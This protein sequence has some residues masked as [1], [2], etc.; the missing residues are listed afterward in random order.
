MIAYDEPTFFK[1]F[2]DIKRRKNYSESNTIT[3]DNFH[4]LIG[5]MYHF[6]EEV[7][8]QVERE[9]NRCDQAHKNGWLG[10]RKDNQEALIGKD[11]GNKYFIENE[12]FRK[13]RERVNREGR[14]ESHISALGSLLQDKQA[15][16]TRWNKAAEKL[17]QTLELRRDTQLALPLLVVDRLYDMVRTGNRAVSVDAQFLEEIDEKGR[18][19]KVWHLREIGAI[20]GVALW[21][22][23]RDLYGTMEG[24]RKAIN[25]AAVSRNEKEA[26]LRNWRETIEQLPQI[27]ERIENFNRGG[28]DFRTEGNLALLCFLVTDQSKQLDILMLLLKVQ[29][30]DKPTRPNAQKLLNELNAQ[31]KAETRSLNIRIV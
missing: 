21:E 12:E 23:N 28:A 29:G 30:Q 19:K 2:A 3:V 22:D 8:C 11:C 17:Q 18:E 16:L 13:E 20:R 6:K 14:I 10:R 25:E 9:G 24:I 31:V 26:T 4:S 7:H 15:L 5:D 27:E 1:D